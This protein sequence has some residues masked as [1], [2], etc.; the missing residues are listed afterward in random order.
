MQTLAIKGATMS[1]AWFRAHTTKSCQNVS[2][3]VKDYL[4]SIH[5][6]YDM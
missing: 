5:M 6:Y 2:H 3:L 1:F 4:A